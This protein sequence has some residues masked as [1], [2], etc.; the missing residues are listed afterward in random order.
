[1]LEEDEDEEDA[2]LDSLDSHLHEFRTE[3]S[4]FRGDLSSSVLPTHDG[5]GSFR[6]DGM[7]TGEAVQDH[8]YAFEQF[9]PRRIKRRRQAAA[10][11]EDAES[12]QAAGLERTR[13]IEEW[14]I[15]QSRLL[16]DEIQ[17][18]TRRR[19]LSMSSEPR[20]L[21]D[22]REQEDVATLSFCGHYCE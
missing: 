14:R 21:S 12:G 1:V 19:R 5:L 11:I 7:M 18:E 10:D 17:K 2:E 20:S 15:E 8:L 13:R 9:N 22:D 6:V 3:P 16:V 4:V